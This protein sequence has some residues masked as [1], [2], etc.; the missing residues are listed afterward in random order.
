M[1][2]FWRINVLL[3]AFSFLL[4]YIGYHK[5][6]VVYKNAVTGNESKKDY[7]KTADNIVIGWSVYNTEQEYFQTMQQ[8]VINRARELNIGVIP[9]DQKSNTSEMITGTMELI[10]QGIDA[11]LISPINPEAMMVVSNLTEEAGIPL[12]VIDVGTGGA[13]IDAFIISDNYGG[14]VLAAEYALRLIREHELS[15][16]NAVIIK[17]EETSTYA[18]RRGE[19]FARVMEDSNIAVVAEVTANSSQKQAY[20][21]MKEILKN[22]GSD[23]AV[24]FSENDTMA[25]GVAQAVNEA[26]LTGKI[27][28]IGFNGDPSAIEA[29]Q[30]GYMQGTIAQQPYEMGA[31]GVEIANTLLNGG[32]I[33]YDDRETKELFSEVYLIDETGTRNR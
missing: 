2:N 15:S 7:V 18:R 3:L 4:I 23:L 29:I 17:T 20:E 28:I 27:M 11:L 22:Y 14:G 30:N 31:L 25:L 33:T 10:A 9:Y 1:K 12:I 13:D 8:G 26:G 24:V 16:R 6:T 5:N 19:A 32:T 21:A